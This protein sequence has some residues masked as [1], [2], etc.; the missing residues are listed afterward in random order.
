MLNQVFRQAKKHPEVP[1]VIG[2]GQVMFYNEG[3]VHP[4]K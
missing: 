4:V 3:T 1:I 2:T